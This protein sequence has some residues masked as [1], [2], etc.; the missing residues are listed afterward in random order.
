MAKKTLTRDTA[1]GK[2]T[3]LCAGLAE[4]TDIDVTFWRVIMLAVVIFT[5]IVPGVAFYLIAS[6]IVAA[7]TS[8]E[9]SNA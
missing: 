7:K 3:G 8:K 9:N 2:I 6:A 1:N 4:Y 5:A